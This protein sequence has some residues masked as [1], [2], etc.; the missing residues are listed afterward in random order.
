MEN[1]LITEK[2]IEQL[3][4]EEKEFVA[5]EVEKAKQDPEVPMSELLQ[6]VY[7]HNDQYFIRGK[8]Y[9]ESR[10]PQGQAH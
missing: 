10:F 6:H 1:Q 5:K 7:L 8:L 3:E 2:E 9:E 4:E